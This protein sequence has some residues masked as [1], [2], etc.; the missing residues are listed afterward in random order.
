MKIFRNTLSIHDNYIWQLRLILELL[1]LI[2]MIVNSFSWFPIN[3]MC[4]PR[5]ICW[6]LNPIRW[7]LEVRPLGG[8]ALW[9][10]I[11]AFINESPENYPTPSPMWGYRKRAIPKPG[12]RLSLDAESAGALTLDF[13][14]SRTVINK[15]LLFRHSLYGTFAIAAWTD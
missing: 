9:K 8:G 11:C 6:N 2:L 4:A 3:W 7:H 5:F 1:I 12:N 13:L 10:G 14:P 15:Y